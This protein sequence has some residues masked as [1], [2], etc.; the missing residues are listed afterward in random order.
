VDAQSYPS[1]PVKMVVGFPRGGGTPREFAD[2]L[3][4]EIAKYAKLVK[5]LDI[6]A[7]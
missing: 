5:Q 6:K 7:E 3:R 4:N 1:K 2:Y